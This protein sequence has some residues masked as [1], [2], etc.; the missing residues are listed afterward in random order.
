MCRVRPRQK[1]VLT[2]A[3]AQIFGSA[4]RPPDP[5]AQLIL[6]LF[7]IGL[8]CFLTVQIMR[9]RFR[10]RPD[11]ILAASGGTD[12]HESNAKGAAAPEA[13]HANALSKG[14]GAAMDISVEVESLMSAVRDQA[15]ELRGEHAKIAS[16]LSLNFDVLANRLSTVQP[17][18]AKAMKLANESK[19]S[20]GLLTVSN[21]DY[22][23]KLAEAERDIALY[24]PLALKTEEDLRL[25]R[26][27]HAET[28]RKFDALEEEHARAQGAHNELFQKMSSAE[29]DHQQTAE[30][31]DA[32]PE[33][34]NEHDSAINR[35]CA[36]TPTLK[37]EIVSSQ[38]ILSEQSTNQDR[39]PRKN[40]KRTL[41][42]ATGPTG[43]NSLRPDS[44]IS[45]RKRGT[46]QT[47]QRARIR[48][49]RSALN[50]GKAILRV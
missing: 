35:F 10:R 23:R 22:K 24:R 13:D 7:I 41:K 2:S 4:G 26:L 1:N 28:K 25:E 18:L 6:L 8:A 29:L 15:V 38:P 9:R 42:M 40:A 49:D 19:T 32:C 27:D 44:I 20:V 34:A 46:D 37:S 50:K 48:P 30:E 33:A 14:E 36:R 21:D 39:S 47:S 12:F 11:L 45:K 3:L 17:L 16:S 5:I 31:K 43:F